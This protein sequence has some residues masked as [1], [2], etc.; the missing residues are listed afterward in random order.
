MSELLDN[1]NA[2][3]GMMTNV[4]G[5]TGWVFLHS[6]TF[7]YPMDPKKFDVDNNLP[8]GT[9]EGRYRDFFTQIGFVFPCRYCRESY[10]E[11]IKEIPIQTESR[12]ALT[13][14]LYDI[15]ERVNKKLGKN[16]GV[17]YEDVVKRYESYRAKCDAKKKGCSVPIGFSMK[18]R[19]CVFVYSEFSL[20]SIVI[21]IV[22]IIL[23]IY[24][25][26]Q[27]K[28]SKTNV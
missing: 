9:T 18:Q 14:W 6:V 4:W 21:S 12:A 26:R 1:P 27:Q 19:S 22:L 8:E 5:P 17:T 25:I 20:T 3:N 16:G 10:Q 28:T 2:A 7:G 11:F 13:K 24:F 15:H 23:L